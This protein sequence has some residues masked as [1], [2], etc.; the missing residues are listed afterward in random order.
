VARA[1]RGPGQ[2]RAGGSAYALVAL[3]LAGSLAGAL[4]AYAAGRIDGAAVVYFALLN[5]GALLLFR[6]RRR[7]GRR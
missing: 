2:S 4:V 1:S 6:P 5:A 7:P 3:V